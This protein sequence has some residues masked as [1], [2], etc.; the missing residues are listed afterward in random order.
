MKSLRITA[1][2][3]A[4]TLPVLTLASVQENPDRPT[5]N[6]SAQKIN[7]SHINIDGR[8][9]DPAWEHAPRQGQF[10]Q[11]NP[12]DGADASQNT[13]FAILYDEHYLYVGIHAYDDDPSQITGILTRRDESSPSDWLYISIDSYHD[14]RTAFEF[15]LNA[16]GVKQ[17]LRRYDDT[18]ADF[19]WDAVWEGAVS[20]NSDGWSAEF[21]IPFRELRFN[22]G[23]NPTWGLNVYRELPGNDNELAIWNY[24]SHEESGFV[25]NYGELTGLNK[26]QTKQPLYI[27]PYIMGQT[28]ANDV[29]LGESD[30]YESLSNVGADIRKNFDLGLTFS[31]TINPDFG[32]VEADPAEFNLTEFE[33]Y[34]SEKRSF[35]IEGG[36]ILNFSLGFGD[37][38]N[39]ANSLFYS[40]RIGRSPHGYEDV[41]DHAEAISVDKRDRTRILAAGKFTGKLDNGLSLGIMTAATPEEKARVRYADGSSSENVIEPATTYVLTRVQQDLREGLTTVGGILTATNRSLD[42][43]DMDW[44]RE[45]AYTA[46]IDLNHNFNDRNYILQSALAYS[47]VAGSKDAI[48]RTQ[49]HPSRYFQRPDAPHLSVDSSA[50]SLTGFG[51]KFILGK[52]SGKVN[53]FAGILGTSPGFEIN[54]LGFMRSVD[55]INQFVWVGYREWE[56]NDYLQNYA[57]NLN[58]W[59]NWTFGSELKSLGG[60]VNGNATL[61]NNWQFG[62]GINY[63]IGGMTPYHLRGGPGVQGPDNVSL[64]SFISS[65]ARKAFF[66]SAS[67]SMFVSDDNVRSYSLSPGLRWRPKK[68]I[69]LSLGPDFTFLD[70]TWA[71]VT[72][73]S[74]STDGI[75]YIFSG[76]EQLATSVTF[77]ADII[78]STTLSL[79]YYTQAFLTGGD[80]HNFI[81]VDDN[82]AKDF[83]ERFA[84]LNDNALDFDVR[85]ALGGVDFDNDGT[86]DYWPV[87]GVDSDFNYKQLTSNLVLRWEY[88]T[89]SVMYLVW[90]R[91]ASQYN[92]AAWANGL[93]SDPVSELRS[94]MGLDADNIFLIKI[95]KLLNI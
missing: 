43:T 31:G 36:N 21:A 3:L 85:G 76:L 94:V 58:Q 83:D 25:S 29:V 46:G 30:A 6:I 86:L 44:L 61:L 18:N 59:A 7:G 27:S 80:Y 22:T 10:L 68:N 39:S 52:T 1:L 67:A 48:L 2:L 17:D 56:A 77:R 45:K 69:S 95:N 8:L 15:G 53:A 54:D 62:G 89:G 16:A 49:L 84:V 14:H 13:E 66:A 33:T 38:D 23:E 51:G 64:W 32:Q 92:Q 12:V 91:G 88:S 73:M 81:E 87:S 65:D 26:I 5:R 50:T 41:L 93:D 55:N 40:R 47:Y 37:G 60:N 24:W 63:N 9:D 71:W 28:G 78:L 4:G 90:S 57:I 34:F 75:H 20:H 72:T 35:F 82:T 11:R 70:D 42:G 74:D 19:D 79:Q